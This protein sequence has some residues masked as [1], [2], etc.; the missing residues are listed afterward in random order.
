MVV[1]VAQIFVITEKLTTHF[2]SI[3]RR[4]EMPK[5]QRYHSGV[6]GGGGGYHSSG[7]GKG[8]RRQKEEAPSTFRN[9]KLT[10]VQTIEQTK[11]TLKRLKKDGTFDSIRS[12]LLNAILQNETLKTYASFA[13]TAST[14]MMRLRNMNTTASEKVN[15]QTKMAIKRELEMDLS[16]EVSNA[17]WNELAEKDGEIARAVQKEI[18]RERKMRYDLKEEKI[19]KRKKMKKTKKVGG[20]LARGGR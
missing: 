17:C 20:R 6:G 14:Q 12:R 13:V 4:F 8:G 15:A 1:L 5:K 18:F 10:P 19:L 3:K 2:L 7:G 16:R 11:T 9:Q